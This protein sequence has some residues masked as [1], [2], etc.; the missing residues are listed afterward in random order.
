[1]NDVSTVPACLSIG[2]ASAGV[3]Q[4]CAQLHL[5]CPCPSPVKINRTQVLCHWTDW[6][7][8]ER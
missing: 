7:S 5:L 1:M 2:Q 3:Q 8:L 4:E 6:A